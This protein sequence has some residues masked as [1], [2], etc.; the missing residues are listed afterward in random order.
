MLQ[1]SPVAVRTAIIVAAYLVAYIALDRISL[2]HPFGALSITPWNPPA[3]L[4]FALLLAHGLRFVPAVFVAVV[5]A[6]VL[7]RDLS[8]APL[9]VA[10]SAL[11]IA[12]GYA[13]A[14]IFL[15]RGMRISLRLD[16]HRDLTWLLVVAL[17]A[18]MGVAAAVIAIFAFGGLLDR[19]DL[20]AAGLRFWVGDVIGIAV[21]TPFLLLLRDPDRRKAVFRLHA[22]SEHALQLGTIALALW[23]V[24]GQDRPDEFTFSY[25]LFLPLIW[26]AMRGGLWGATWGI[27]ATQLGLIFAIQVRGFDAEVVTQFQLLMLAVAV[28]GLF[29]GAVVD[30]RSRA[31]RSLRD[32]EAWLQTIV[33]TAPDAILTF[34]E[35]GALV[36]VNR[37]AEQMFQIDGSP[38]KQVNIRKLLPGL[39]GASVP[40]AGREMTAQRCDG[41]SFIAE[42]ATGQ[43]TM[44]SRSV[45]VAI[46]RDISARKQ[47][48]RW[49]K[50][51]EAELAHAARLTATGEMA[52]ALAHELNQPLTAL[53]SFARAAQAL[54]KSS[55]RPE[56]IPASEVDGFLDQAVQ[57]AARAGE[58]IRSTRELLRQSDPRREKAELRRLIDA[59]FDLVRAEAVHGRFHV[60]ARIDRAL[61]PVLVDPIQIEQ[62]ILNLIRNSIDAMQRANSPRREITVSATRANGDFVEVAVADTGPGIAV[63]VA[64]RLF[65]P[66]ATTKRS[67][68]GLGLS[69]SRSLVEG[70]GG[71]IWVVPSPPG[72]GVEIRFTV[73]VYKEDVDG[74]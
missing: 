27:V 26:I 68:M 45:W 35:S 25:V 36:S 4:S 48:E 41:G 39:D 71:R 51:H 53:I 47:A 33:A 70:H 57:Q 43:A 44:G 16:N 55:D 18:A 67:G 32:S 69:I 31:E 22:V 74:G 49:L 29:L 12:L 5:L 34:E 2:I 66:F 24:F 10:E 50:E 59:V 64:D 72:G 65:T 63:E 15:R 28:S 61:P 21:L 14:A 56:A 62:V 19:E 58:I 40:I 42:V 54:V 3:G 11:A 8:V 23:I 37:A 9:G 6:D 1:S 7:F 60:N 52:A 38:M 73:P 20:W 46:V 17:V 13:G 30:E